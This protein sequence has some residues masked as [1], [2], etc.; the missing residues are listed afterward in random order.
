MDR[1]EP[2]RIG[3]RNLR[4]EEP[5]EKVDEWFEDEFYQ[6]LERYVAE[7]DDTEDEDYTFDAWT[8]NRSHAMIDYELEGYEDRTD[9]KV[10]IAGGE[11]AVETVLNAF[12]DLWGDSGLG[13]HEA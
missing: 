13:Y 9:I 10:D 5:E 7:V 3:V 1:S 12:D 6:G 4:I 11:L 8:H 2:H